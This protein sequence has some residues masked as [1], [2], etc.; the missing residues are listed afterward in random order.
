MPAKPKAKPRNAKVGIEAKRKAIAKAYGINPDP[1]NGLEG[2]FYGR[3]HLAKMRPNDHGFREL[4]YTEE[5]L[6]LVE[7]IEKTLRGIRERDG[8][9]Y[10]NEVAVDL[11]AEIAWEIR[12][13]SGRRG[14]RRALHKAV[15]RA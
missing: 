15:S 1:G 9:K 13:K 7:A 10:F 5:R 14:L 11:L 8:M 2:F 3:R 12:D 6:D 4:R